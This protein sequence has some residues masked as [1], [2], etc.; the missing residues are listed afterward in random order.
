MSGGR[1]VTGGGGR[2]AAPQGPS[3]Q[4]PPVCVT[5]SHCQMLQACLPPAACHPS[6]PAM[7][8]Q[9]GGRGGAP[10]GLVLPEEQGPLL[11]GPTLF[12]E[13]VPRAPDCWD[14]AGGGPAA[15]AACVNGCGGLGPR[16][17]GWVSRTWSC[18]LRGAV[19]R[20]QVAWCCTG[21]H[22]PTRCPPSQ[23]GC[24]VGN[25]LFPLL[26]LSPHLRAWAC[27]FA[28]SAI[29]LVKAHPAYGPAAA[30]GRCAWVHLGAVP[31]GL[32]WRGRPLRLGTCGTAAC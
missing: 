23:V 6:L 22:P 2:A 13:G 30:A 7:C 11:Q 21:T 1:G 26:E 28:P 8:S 25:A 5:C 17:G 29:E 20:L 9:A 10:L 12:S 19:G 15:A 32:R 31:G 24:G 18:Q 3:P 14:G 27:D 16:G 4:Q